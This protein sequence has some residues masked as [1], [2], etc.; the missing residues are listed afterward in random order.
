[1]DS[2]KIFQTG[3]SQAVRLPKA[4]RFEGS[5]VFLK[6]MGRAVVLMPEEDSWD[7]L[8]EACDGFSEDFL[9]ERDQPEHQRRLAFGE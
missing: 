1:M 4:Y 2:A 3:R 7:L 9:R 6:R 8:F 5:E